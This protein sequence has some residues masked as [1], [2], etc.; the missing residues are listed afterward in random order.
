MGFFRDLFSQ[1]YNLKD[2]KV[3][4]RRVERERKKHFLEMRKLSARQAH[5]V[6]EI[7]TAR[8]NGNQIEVD[9]MWEE[10][11]DLKHEVNFTKRA[12]RVA[13][14]EGITL[15]RYVHGIERLERSKDKSGIQ[16]MI[17]RIQNSG[18]DNKL[19]MAQINEEEYLDEL[20][21]ILEASGLEDDYI[22]GNAADPEKARFLSEIDAIN[23]AEEGGEF[24]TALKKE[25]ELKKMLEK[26]DQETV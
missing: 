15:K 17:Q 13:N 25:G 3:Q 24:E 22:D 26:D 21:G 20:N 11:K 1:G 12:A 18:L 9:Y 4:L 6:E 2:M 19:A 7:K 10:L 23:R 14:L 5:L 8:K 16:N